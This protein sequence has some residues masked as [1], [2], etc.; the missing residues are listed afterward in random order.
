MIASTG[1]VDYTNGVMGPE[2]LTRNT[3]TGR[4]G[5]IG[6]DTKLPA[7]FKVSLANG[8]SISVVRRDIMDSALGRGTKK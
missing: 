4:I 3:S 2:K 6:K 7:T 5:V 8:R 1:V